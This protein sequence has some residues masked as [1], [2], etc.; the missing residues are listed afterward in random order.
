MAPTPCHGVVN[1]KLKHD[2]EGMTLDVQS[3]ISEHGD[4]TE[5]RISTLVGTNF[6]DG[7]GNVMIGAE[8]DHREGIFARNRQ[9]QRDYWADPTTNGNQPDLT[10]YTPTAFN[11]PSQAA[12]DAVFSDLPPGS[13]SP[14]S[15]FFVNPGGGSIFTL[16]GPGL[17]H[18]T[19]P[20]DNYNYKI[21][22]GSLQQNFVE[23]YL[24][25]PLARY[26]FY[27]KAE[28]NL[29]DDMTFYAQGNFSDVKVKQIFN[30]VPATSFWIA[31]PANDANHPVPSDLAN[32]LDNRVDIGGNPIPADATYQLSRNLNFLGG[33]RRGDNLT[34]SYQVLA[35]LK[36]N[37]PFKDWT[38]DVYGS[39]GQTTTINKGYSYASTTRWRALV[40]GIPSPNVPLYSGFPGPGVPS[41]NWGQNFL[42]APVLGTQIS[43]T[44]GLP[45]FADFTP[46]QDCLDADRPD[47]GHHVDH[48]TG[49]RGS[50]LPGWPVQS[51]GGRASWCVGHDLSAGSLR[52]QAGHDPRP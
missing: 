41:V 34:T 1:F 14:T 51:A 9:W 21:A 8:W 24:S 5:T 37:L 29:N 25:S 42:Y 31:T 28:Y 7:R 38:Y 4:G 3:G 48:Q 13:V 40:Q 19:G 12:V 18:Y 49:Y 15:T 6:A 45:L 17:S 10:F 50:Q 43:C 27:G 11:H 46:S 36:G 52:L 32:L 44:S 47:L 26:T 39:H 35:G 30:Y 20:I 23:G 2:Y 33:P 22:N 16:S